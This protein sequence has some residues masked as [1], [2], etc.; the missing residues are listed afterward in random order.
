MNIFYILNETDQKWTVEDLKARRCTVLYLD[1][2]SFNMI[3]IDT[4]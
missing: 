3:L 1:D 4:K 2:I